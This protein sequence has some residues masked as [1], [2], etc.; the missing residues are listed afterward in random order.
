MIYQVDRI[1]ADVRIALD[2]NRVDTALIQDADEDTLS[3]NELIRSKILEGV[4]RVHSIA[5]YY[6]LEQ[7]HNINDDVVDDEG[8][9]V[10]YAPGVHWEDR[11]SGWIVLPDDF[12][13][14]VVFEM[15]DW[16]RPVYKVITPAD[17]AYKRQRCRIKALRGTAQRPVCALVVRPEGKTLEFYSCKSESATITKAVYM[18]YPRI[19]IYGG[20]DISE[21]CYRA[22]IYAIAWLTA[23]ACGE[24]DNATQLLDKSNTYLQK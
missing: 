23:S 17:P 21:R 20:V 22:A 16:E 15:S 14:L 7:G 24:A 1:L 11:E 5:P 9:T 12:M 4:E 10:S 13:R 2:E 8:E 3:L 6:M 19:D 18:P